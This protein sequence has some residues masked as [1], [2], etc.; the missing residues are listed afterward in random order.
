MSNANK[1]GYEIRLEI[2]NEAISIQ[3]DKF[4]SELELR[5][6]M[7]GSDSTA[8]YKIPN[9]L[10]DDEKISNLAFKLY[11]FVSKEK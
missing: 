10:L 9:D 8:S 5:K 1:S 4:F 11:E 7:V 3:K 6:R 2:L